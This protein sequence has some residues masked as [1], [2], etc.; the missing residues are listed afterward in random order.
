MQ[1]KSKSSNQL[2]PDPHGIPPRS[3][4][5]PWWRNVGYNTIPPA[6]TGVNPSNSSS[7]EGLNGSESN[8]GLSMSDD[9]VDEEDND[10]N[11]ESHNAASSQSGN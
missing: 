4:S 7:M 8:D 1:P 10:A 9:E 3:Y 6:G 2:E 11:K 5:E